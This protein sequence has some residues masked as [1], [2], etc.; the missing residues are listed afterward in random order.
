MKD[1]R[2]RGE[3]A[4]EARGQGVGLRELYHWFAPWLG[5]VLLVI[6]ALLGLFTASAAR[7][8][9]DFT[10]GLVTFILAIIALARGIRNYFDGV[11]GGFWSPVLVVDPTALLL[12]VILLAGLAVLGLV[13][14]ARARDTVWQ[15]SGYA[16]FGTSIAVIAWN[17]KHYFDWHDEKERRDLPDRPAT[18]AHDRGRVERPP[19]P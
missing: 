19:P 7:D 17:L 5:G 8:S 18:P 9:G 11:G 4:A 3:P 13:L 1:D 16:L 10:A 6:V 12:L 2:G 15:A 14:A